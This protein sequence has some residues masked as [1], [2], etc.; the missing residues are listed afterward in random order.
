MA[1]CWA[2]MSLDSAVRVAAATAAS[3]EAPGA[4]VIFAR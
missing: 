2:G 1:A 4:G 3:T